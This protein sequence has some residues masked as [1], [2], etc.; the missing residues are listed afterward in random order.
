MRSHNDNVY[1]KKNKKD[2]KQQDSLE[3]DYQFL[4]NLDGKIE[5]PSEEDYYG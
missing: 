4:E 3:N 5:P 1:K 2:L